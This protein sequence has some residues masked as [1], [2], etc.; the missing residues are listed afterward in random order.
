VHEVDRDLPTGIF[1]RGEAFFEAAQFIFVHDEEEEVLRHFI[2]FFGFFS[3]R[4]AIADAFLFLFL[5]VPS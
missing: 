1:R 5:W 2:R 3:S 4:T